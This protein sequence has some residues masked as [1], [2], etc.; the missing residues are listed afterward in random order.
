MAVSTRGIH[1]SSGQGEIEFGMFV[2]PK[3]A[4]LPPGDRVA[5]LARPAVRSLVELTRVGIPV[6]IGAGLMGRL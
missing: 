2:E 4:G 6:A 3:G 5:A 1:V